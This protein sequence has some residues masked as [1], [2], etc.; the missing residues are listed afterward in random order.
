VIAPAACSSS[1]SSTVPSLLPVVVQG[2]PVLQVYSPND[3]ADLTCPPDSCR[4]TTCSR[5]TRRM[6]GSCR[7]SDWR[8]R[9]IAIALGRVFVPTPDGRVFIVQAAS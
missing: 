8:R 5:S 7:R 9:P 4:P 1:T 3:D 6:A 2:R